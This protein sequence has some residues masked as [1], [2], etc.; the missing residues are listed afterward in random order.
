MLNYVCFFLDFTFYLQIE[1]SMEYGLKLF[2]HFNKTEKE[3][4][5]TIDIY[6]KGHSNTTVDL[7]YLQIGEFI[8]GDFNSTL[9]Y[10]DR[11]I[12]IV[13]NECEKLSEI[14]DYQIVRN[15]YLKL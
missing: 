15:L 2:S 4:N 1:D 10:R 5:M 3:L 13:L 9:N 11:D 7:L 8:Y 14:P 6:I 12:I